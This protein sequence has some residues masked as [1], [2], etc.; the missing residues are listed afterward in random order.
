MSISSFSSLDPSLN[1][2]GGEFPKCYFLL[3]SLLGP[4]VFLFFMNYLEKEICSDIVYP[5]VN[6]CIGHLL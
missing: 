5:A 4:K 1:F 3:K 2:T 6:C